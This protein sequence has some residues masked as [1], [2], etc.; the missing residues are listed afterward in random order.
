[1]TWLKFFELSLRDFSTKTYYLW[2]TKIIYFTFITNKIIFL[3]GDNKHDHHT[4]PDLDPPPR[5]CDL[6]PLS[7]STHH[8]SSFHLFHRAF[9]I[10]IWPLLKIFPQKYIRRKIYFQK[11][12]TIVWLT[13][14]RKQCPETFSMEAVLQF[15]LFD[16]SGRSD[17]LHELRLCRL[18]KKR[19]NLQIFNRG[20][21]GI[22]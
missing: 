14:L 21:I 5:N 1:M 11:I 10:F 12:F 2:H 13:F 9:D 16:V 17:S 19:R 18:L 15:F 22:I 7:P 6:F 8:L 3:N 20:R 4:Y